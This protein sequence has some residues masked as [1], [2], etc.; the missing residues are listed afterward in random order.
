MPFARALL[1]HRPREVRAGVDRRLE[2]GDLQFRTRLAPACNGSARTAAA[3]TAMR[4]RRVMAF[5]LVNCF[6]PL[7][8]AAWIPACDAARS[9]RAPAAAAG[10]AMPTRS[11]DARTG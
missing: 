3:A 11:R 7:C 4:K 8:S 10:S 2:D 5:L 6:S 9:R 1:H